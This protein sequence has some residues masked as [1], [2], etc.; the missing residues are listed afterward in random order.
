MNYQLNNN[1][2]GDI[3]MTD[4]KHCIELYEYLRG[5]HLT[6][7]KMYYDKCKKSGIYI[8][9]LFDNNIM[10]RNA[11]YQNHH[12]I[13]KWLYYIEPGR[14]HLMERKIYN[15]VEGTTTLLEHIVKWAAN[16]GNIDILKLIYDIIQDCKDFK[17]YKDSSYSFSL[18]HKSLV[19][20]F[21]YA[22]LLKYVDVVKWIMKIDGEFGC[23]IDMKDNRIYSLFNEVYYKDS[24]YCD[25]VKNNKLEICELFLKAGFK[26]GRNHPIYYY[27]IGILEIQNNYHHKYLNII[28]YNV[29][30]MK[31]NNLFG[32]DIIMNITKKYL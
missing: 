14:I 24:A 13:A 12:D 5:Q 15:N 21:R 11:C 8:D 22:C 6:L 31:K 7:A 28:L 10:F 29:L 20:N 18:Y 23:T 26:P 17:D 32:K 19:D 16:Y 9:I 3:N 4:T 1:S 2:T 25:Y 30:S 27:S